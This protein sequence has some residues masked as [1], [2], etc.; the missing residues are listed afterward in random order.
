MFGSFID[1]E[2][3]PGQVDLTDDEGGV[4]RESTSF[5]DRIEATPDAAYPAAHGRYH[6]YVSLAC[7]WAHRTLLVRALKGLE[8]AVTV[9]VLDPYRGEMGWQFTPA[10][11]GCTRDT[12]NGF[13]YL[14]ETYA[15]ADPEYT[16]QVTVPVLWDR[17]TGTIVNNESREIMRML[18]VAFE[19]NGVDL[20]PEEYREA[21]DRTIDQ[22]YEPIN[23][24]VYRAGFADSQAAYDE[25]VDRLFDALDRWDRVLADQRYLVSEE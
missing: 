2:F 13:E 21:V 9:D 22:L 5:R 14:H 6:L 10:R 8:D 3:H 24:G 25:A 16:G 12:V 19:G 23:N 18:D 4:V 7:P 11:D 1:G 20:Y 17:Q 15:A